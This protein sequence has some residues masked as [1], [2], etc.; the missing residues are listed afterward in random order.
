MFLRPPSLTR[1]W[2]N[3]WFSIVQVVLC[4]RLLLGAIHRSPFLWTNPMSILG[5]S[6]VIRAI[7]LDIKAFLE[8]LPP[9]NPT[10]VGAP[11]NR[12]PIWTAAFIVSVFGLWEILLLFLTWQIAVNLL[13]LA[14]AAS[15]IWVMSVTDVSVLLWKLSARTP[16]RLLGALTPSAVRWTNVAETHLV[17]TLA[18]PLSTL[19]SPMLLDLTS[20]AIR[21]VLV[22]TEPLSSLPIMDV[23]CLIILLVVTSLVAR[24]LRIRTIVTAPLSSARLGLGR[25]A[26]LA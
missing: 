26:L 4:S 14:W 5:R 2:S 6:S 22:L 12:L 24:P 17:L 7:A 9:R 11:Q 16:A 20:M 23:G 13:I 8:E 10:W 3:L 18:L 15:L 25:V 1:L 19:T 21:A